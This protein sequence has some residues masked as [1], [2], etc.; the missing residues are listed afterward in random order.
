MSSSPSPLADFSTCE[1]SDALIK[2]GHLSGGHIPDLHPISTSPTTKR[3]CGPAFTVKM[4]LATNKDAPKLQGH[5]VDMIESGCVAFV[6]A[7]ASAQNAVWGGLMTLGAQS[8]NC[9]GTIVHGRIRDTSEHIAA[10]YPLYALGTSTVGQSPH[11]RASEVQV[12]LVVNSGEGGLPGVEVRPGDILVADE[13]GVVCVPREVE[14]K[15][16]ELARKGRKVD[17]RCAEDIRRGVGVQEA[18]RRHRGKL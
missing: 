16:E 7:P 1:L 12:P 3:L 6:A 14:G 13:D 9:L 17:E 8:R 11:T 18:F 15:V 5:F 2:L 10:S 4:V